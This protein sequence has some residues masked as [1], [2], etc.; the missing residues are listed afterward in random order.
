MKHNLGCRDL[1]KSIWSPFVYGPSFFSSTSPGQ[2]R[3]PSLSGFSLFVVRFLCDFSKSQFL[4][5][6]QKKSKV[7]TSCTLTWWCFEP[8]CSRW[9]L[10]RQKGGRKGQ[11]VHCLLLW[12]HPTV[13][14]G[15]FCVCTGV[16]VVIKPTFDWAMIRT[17]SEQDLLCTD[18]FI[19][20]FLIFKGDIESRF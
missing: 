14:S 18:Y 19:Q 13:T 3:D 1:S 16:K 2:W 8:Y 15:G 12:L 9:C 11:E 5:N 10:Q 20:T 7:T 17:S 4:L 6:S